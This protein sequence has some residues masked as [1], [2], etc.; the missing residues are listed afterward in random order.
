M[1]KLVACTKVW[2]NLGDVH[3]PMWRACDC[4]EYIIAR[5]EKEPA[6]PEIGDAVKKF[7]HILEGRISD[8]TIESYIGFELYSNNSLT[9]GENFQLEQ[10]GT[11]DFP[12]EDVT[13]IDVRSEMAGIAGEIPQ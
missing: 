12:A 9:H 7:M 3:L 13:Q 1:L 11:I 5:F 2:Q 6:W 4:N 10:G 8:N